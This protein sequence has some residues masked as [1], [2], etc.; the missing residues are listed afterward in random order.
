MPNNPTVNSLDEV[1]NAMGLLNFTDK[2]SIV[3]LLLFFS[4]QS[5]IQ[6]Q[7]SMFRILSGILTIG[8]LEFSIDE[9]GFTRQNFDEEK[10]RQ[11]LSIIA[12]RK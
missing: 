9:E 10:I 3:L 8:N 12:V 6:E 4:H 7:H 11:D 1:I 2:V 5:F